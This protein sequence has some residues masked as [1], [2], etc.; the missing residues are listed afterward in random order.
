MNVNFVIFGISKRYEGELCSRLN[1]LL[2]ADYAPEPIYKYINYIV[3]KP[4]DCT[5]PTYNCANTIY[6]LAV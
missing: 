2:R 6:V 4:I 1:L 5:V 3:P